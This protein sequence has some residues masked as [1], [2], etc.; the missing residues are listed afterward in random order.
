MPV[1]LVDG[2]TAV[3]YCYSDLG[4]SHMVLKSLEGLFKSQD[5]IKKLDQNV[6]LSL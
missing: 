4:M 2:L 3:Q 6:K 1:L 5:D